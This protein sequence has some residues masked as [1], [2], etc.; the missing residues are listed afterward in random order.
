M[1]LFEDDR[2]APK[3]VHEIG[4]DLSALSVEELSAR[5]ELLKAEI[6]RIEAAR[7]KKQAQKSAADAFFRKG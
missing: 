4:Q 6:T 7:D 2:P 3:R 5:I 1:A